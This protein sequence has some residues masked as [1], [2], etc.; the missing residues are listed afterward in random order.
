VLLYSGNYGIAHEVETFV[1][2]YRLHHREGTGR[3]RLWLSATG[4]GAEEVAGRL[5]ALGL[6]FHRSKP[7][8][9]ERLAGLLKAPDAHLVVLK[10]S[11]V[12]FVMPS[13]IYACLGSRKPLIF[14]GSADSDVDL[15]GQKSGVP[16]WRV[17][18]G[19]P[20]GLSVALEMLADRSVRS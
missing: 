5:T 4:T 6:P 16:Y 2:G 17:S 10:D 13:K 1:E 9:L 19:D 20:K 14:V 12:G 15:L 3:A 18:C 7:V 11:F 8:P